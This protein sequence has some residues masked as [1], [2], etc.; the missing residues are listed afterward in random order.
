MKRFVWPL[1]MLALA[2]L[3]VAQEKL[4]T[5]TELPYQNDL[6]R[7]EADRQQKEGSLYTAE[8]TVRVS[9]RDIRIRADRLTFD[10]ATRRVTADGDILYEKGM[11]R[12]QATHAEYNLQSD[13]GIFHE[14]SGHTDEQFIFRAQ[15]IE[16]TGEDTYRVRHGLLTTCN[17][18]NPKWQFQVRSAAIRRNRS[19]WIRNTV[20]RVKGIPVFY[21]PYHYIPLT[22]KERSSGFLFPSTGTSN[23]KGRR[24]SAS[25]YLVL[26]RS[27]D[28]TVL[29]DYFTKRGLGYGLNL[30]IR[31]NPSSR[32]EVIS[33]S[34]NDRKKQGGSTILT[35]AESHFRNGFRGVVNLNVVSS[36]QFRQIFND[37][38]RAA[39]IPLDTSRIFFTNNFGGYS[40]NFV[41]AREETLFAP[42]SVIVRNAPL[43]NFK[44]L[45]APLGRLPLVLTFGGSL[46]GLK[47]EDPFKSTPNF[48]QRLDLFPR[49]LLRRQLLGPFALTGSLGFR[50][51]F[52]SDSLAPGGTQTLSGENLSREYAEGTLELDGPQLERTFESPSRQLKHTLQPEVTYR[53]LRGVEDFHR[54]IRFDDVDAVA[55]THEV[56]Y[57]LMNRLLVKT[58]GSRRGAREW[59]S[60][61]IS[62]RYFLDPDF[63]GALRAGEASQFYPLYTLTPFLYGGIPRRFSPL[64][65]RLRFSPRSG[66]DAEGR[67]DYDT[68]FRRVRNLSTS[69]QYQRG[70]FGGSLT[71]YRTQ[72][73]EAG[74]FESHQIQS[75]LG[76]GASTRGFSGGVTVSYNL[77]TEQLLNNLT[78][79]NY[80]W[81]CCGVSLE[82]QQFDVGL[83]RES[84]VRFAFTLKGLG[85]FGTIRRPDSLF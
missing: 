59:L 84:Q 63:G 38:F 72:R 7:I 33:Y 73:L 20:F 83:R 3:A 28:A 13:T 62:Q 57:A 46:E 42:R 55:E 17:E 44:S 61:R 67:L 27:A 23:A 47:R 51:T 85:S 56:E 18:E 8:G 49:V 32:I 69:G 5:M 22:R 58:A 74:T 60:F 80:N 10:D 31:P 30:R 6:L 15:H 76:Y 64:V 45:G 75:S 21:L 24:V 70:L 34:V 77:Q 29:G 68:R 37:E 81:D 66:F 2:P 11:A 12:I 65:S 54:I 71:Y 14:A 50:E 78:R 19:A 39:T 79:I 48:V 1:W 35:V 36:F 82:F 52:Y 40:A 43:L 9:F 41:Y 26:G 16:K 53:N 4:R 25:Y